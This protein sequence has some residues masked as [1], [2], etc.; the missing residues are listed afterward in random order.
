MPFLRK[1]R[2][3]AVKPRFD[4]AE[5]NVERVGDLVVTHALEVRQQENL[6]ERPRKFVNGPLHQLAALQVV[7]GR[8]WLGDIHLHQVNVGLGPAS[9]TVM[10]LGSPSAATDWGGE[11]EGSPT[12]TSTQGVPP[13]VRCDREKPGLEPPRRVKGLSRQV[14]LKEGLLKGIL[15]HRP[16]PYQADEKTHQVIV[17]T[18]DQELERRCVTPAVVRYEFFVGALTSGLFGGGGHAAGM[19]VGIGRRDDRNRTADRTRGRFARYPSSRLH[20]WDCPR[21][22]SEGGSKC[23]S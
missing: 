2:D 6:T 7:H 8:A 4:R 21:G 10:A 12:S 16:I 23:G 22:Q 19:A 3:R 11:I 17:V 20:Y 9:R 5:R 14:D 1:G 13:L 18:P 15:G